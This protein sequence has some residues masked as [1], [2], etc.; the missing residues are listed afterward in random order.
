[1]GSNVC[2][3]RKIP[4]TLM[5]RCSRASATFS[6]KFLTVCKSV[7]CSVSVG[8]WVPWYACESQRAVGSWFFLTVTSV[9]R[10]MEQALLSA[11]SS[12]RSTPAILKEVQP[13]Y[14]AKGVHNLLGLNVSSCPS[15]TSVVQ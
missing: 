8:P 1:M 9:V 12:P 4:P 7:M 11:G 3:K 14:V 6:F 2:R 10:P 5:F 15:W 13:V